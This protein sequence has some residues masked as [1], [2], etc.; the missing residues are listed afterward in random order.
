MKK[1]M[2][3][4]PE[5]DPKLEV[6]IK[7]LQ[8]HTPRDPQAASRTRD[9]FLAE[10]T[11]IS[12]RVSNLPRHRLEEWKEKF[13]IFWYV[14]KKE[15]STM[16]KFAMSIFLVLGLVLGVGATTVVAAQSAQPD[17][18]LYPVKIWS[19]DVRLDLETD[20]QVKLELALQFAAR[21]TEEIRTLFVA[22]N[23]VPEEVMTRFES[24]Q[25]QA[26]NFAADMPDE[27]TAPAL[28]QVRDQARQQNQFMAQLQVAEPAAQQTRAR[29]QN[30]LQTQEQMALQGIQDR[31]WLRQQLRLRGRDRIW[32]FT[33]TIQVTENA[34]TPLS[35]SNSWTNGTPTPG[36]G[37]GPGGSHN[38]WT[39]GTP[40]PG[41]GYGPGPGTGDCTTCTPKPRN[42][43]PAEQPSAGNGGGDGENGNGDNGEGGQPAPGGNGNGNK[44]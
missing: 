44:P 15:K 3:P 21:R 23:T 14:S 6:L 12:P 8:L 10:A 41:S 1:P 17:E 32:F 38:P 42:G 27:R 40:T 28:E 26:M 18:T 33:P 37:Y 20:P 13:T 36:S 5:L 35:G 22:G 39:D 4:N 25:Q 19:E 31:E 34:M 11:Q 16:F 29:I 2:N 7:S 30:M 43:S 24:Q 9:S